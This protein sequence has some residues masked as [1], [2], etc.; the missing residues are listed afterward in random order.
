VYSLQKFFQE[1]NL[2]QAGIL[3]VSVCPILRARDAAVPVDSGENSSRLTSKE[4][5]NFVQLGSN[6]AEFIK[7]MPGA[8]PL[9]STG[10][11]TG[12]IRAR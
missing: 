1:E 11:G 7:M 8:R 9:A 4:L 12:E 2:L 10:M 6:A 3:F 5:M